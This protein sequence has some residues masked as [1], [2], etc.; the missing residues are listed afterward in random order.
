MTHRSLIKLDQF[1]GLKLKSYCTNLKRIKTLSEVNE[2]PEIVGLNPR[3]IIG[4]GTN[5]FFLSS[6]K[7]PL[8]AIVLLN[9]LKGIE[10]IEKIN[11][12]VYVRCFAGENWNDFV[13][14]TLHRNI[15][16]LENLVSIPGSVGA[17]PIQNIGA[18]GVEVGD[19][20]SSISVWD[21]KLK[22]IKN[23]KAK[24]CLFG[25]RDSIFKK[26][27]LVDG[28]QK[29]RYFVLS[30]DFVL[31]PQKTSP[32]ITHYSGIKHEID[33]QPTP[34]KIAEVIKK[35]RN[36]K[37][38]N[39]REIPN[40]GSFF[41]NPIIESSLA[42]RLRKQYPNLPEFEKTL[43]S[44]KVSAAWLIEESNLKGYRIGDAGV[45]NKHSLIVVN[46]GKATPYEIM[47]LTKKIQT[48]V[49]EKYGI[50]LLPEPSII[51]SFEKIACSLVVPR[52]QTYTHHD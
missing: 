24:D 28:W 19:R 1:N 6:K 25:Y 43:S 14:W 38:P 36:S 21:F 44:S 41:Q 47:R 42:N 2:L 10:E 51:S 11:N 49:L 52:N 45:Y 48:T 32:L 23:L 16:G 13:S 37:L 5:I 27:M 12:R 34:M 7:I 17:A 31:W 26:Q 35:I 46:H 9:Q 33:G 30:V 15:G 8:S 20:I 3:L 40:V 22:K 4:H 50:W 18:Y 29:T 39:P